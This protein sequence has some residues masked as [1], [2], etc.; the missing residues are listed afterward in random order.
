M[1]LCVL[2]GFSQ[3]TTT[4]PQYSGNSDW[5]PVIID[6]TPKKSSSNSSSS[7]PIPKVQWYYSDGSKTTSTSRSSSSYNTSSSNSSKRSFGRYISRYIVEKNNGKMVFRS[8]Y[9]PL[10]I[11]SSVIEVKNTNK[12]TKTWAVKYQGPIRLTNSGGSERFHNF[13]LTNH[14]VEFNISDR[15]IHQY[16]G[17]SYYVIIFDGQ[18]QLAE[19]VY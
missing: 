10:T 4:T 7:S 11:T 17:K 15:P 18:I 19:A 8:I 5:K 3:S 1:Y 2:K 16:Q 13:Y 6:D 12:G 9:N 14:H